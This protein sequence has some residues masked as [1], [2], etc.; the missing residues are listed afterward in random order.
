MPKL[1]P[2]PKEFG[3]RRFATYQT[4]PA[5]DEPAPEFVPVF[6]PPPLTDPAESTAARPDKES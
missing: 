5:D 3:V 4:L 2:T 6:A 1:P